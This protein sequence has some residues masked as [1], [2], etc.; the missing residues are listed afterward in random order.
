MV[1]GGQAPLY[2][3]RLLASETGRSR[4][5]YAA[6]DVRAPCDPGLQL[7]AWSCL[8]HSEHGETGKTSGIKGKD[9]VEPGSPV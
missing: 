4:P 1:D 7:P 2:G 6:E 8:Q 9:G 5:L 3:N